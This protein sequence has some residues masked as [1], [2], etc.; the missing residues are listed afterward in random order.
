MT[1]FVYLLKRRISQLYPEEISS[2]REQRNEYSQG[3]VRGGG[4][5]WEGDWGTGS[6]TII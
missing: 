4:G 2:G 1:L 5:E 3:S 6:K